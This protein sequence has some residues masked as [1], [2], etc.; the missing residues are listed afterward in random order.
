MVLE[1]VEDAAVIAVTRKC[2]LCLRYGASIPCRVN[3]CNSCF[4]FLCAAGAGCL[5]DIESLELLCPVHI[6]EALTSSKTKFIRCI[7]NCW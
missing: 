7:V 5:Q 4:H 1:G 6:S 2:S 3:D